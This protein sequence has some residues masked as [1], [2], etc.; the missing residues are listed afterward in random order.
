[1][2]LGFASEVMREELR[3]AHELAASSPPLAGAIQGTIA[4]CGTPSTCPLFGYS[5]A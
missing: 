4:R 3:A 2:Q 1:V 5:A